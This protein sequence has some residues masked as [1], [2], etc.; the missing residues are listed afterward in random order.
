MHRL[1]PRLPIVFFTTHED[2]DQLF[3]ATPGGASGYLLKRTSPERLFE[4]IVDVLNDGDLSPVRIALFVRRYFQNLV[5]SLCFLESAPDMARLTQRERE[6]LNLL[7]KGCLDK[8][9]ADTLGISLWT[10]HG[11]LKKIYE[12]LG[13]HTRTEAAI[14][15]LHK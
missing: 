13:V 2:S 9:I 8:E 4:P 3:K 11:H 6:I 5:E 12:K 14:R 1:C 7:S 10:V 15:Y